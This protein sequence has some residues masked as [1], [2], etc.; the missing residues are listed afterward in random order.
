MP[1][2]LQ[3]PLSLFSV[4]TNSNQ[5]T[6]EALLQSKYTSLCFLLLLLL[7]LVIPSFSG[8]SGVEAYENYTV[9][10][11]SG[12]Y[13]SVNYQKWVAAK[14][15]SLGDFLSKLPFITIHQFLSFF[16]LSIDN[17]MLISIAISRKLRFNALM[18][19]RSLS[20]SLLLSSGQLNPINVNLWQRKLLLL[21]REL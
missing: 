18:R 8:I 20:I 12:W 14:T 2:I 4:F 7:P 13:E 1:F 6:M 11:S 21:V 19:V 16:A 10:D 3:Y 9:G 15:F 17:I 5:K